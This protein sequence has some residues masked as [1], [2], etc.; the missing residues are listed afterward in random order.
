MFNLPYF[1]E[2]FLQDFHKAEI[3]SGG[4]VAEAYARMIKTMRNSNRDSETPSELKS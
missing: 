4:R 3:K 1:N 2:Y